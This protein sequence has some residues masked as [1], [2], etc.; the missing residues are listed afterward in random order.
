M[1]DRI[2][3]ILL[4]IR[5]DREAFAATA[6]GW[7]VEPL[8]PWK[9]PESTLG[10]AG[11][12]ETLLARP[13][14]VDHENPWDEAYARMSLR[15]EVLYAEPDIA[16]E[17]QPVAADAAGLALSGA[18]QG[19]SGVPERPQ[20]E[21]WH[22][23]DGYSQ[24]RR[25]RDK[26][27]SEGRDRSI[28][29]GILDTGYQPGHPLLPRKLRTDLGRDFTD[30]DRSSA[31]EPVGD[32]PFDNFGHGTSTMVL[33]AGQR[34][35]LNDTPGGAPNAEVLPVRI[36]E[37]VVLVYT[38]SM[39]R[40]IEYAADQ[41]CHV[42]SVSMGGLASQFWADAVNKAY[43]EG[44]CIV[45]ASGNNFGAPKAIVYPALFRR[46]IAACGVMSDGS[47]YILPFGQMSGNFGPNSKMDTALAAYTPDVVWARR[48]NTP[49]WSGS[50]AEAFDLKG[51]GTSS[52]T[53]QIAAAA[54]L[55]LQMHGTEFPSGGFASGWVRVENVRR[56][57]FQSARKQ[58][59]ACRCLGIG[60]L[61]ALRALEFQPSLAVTQTPRDNARLAFLKVLTGLGVEA[62]SPLTCMIGTEV[63]QLWQLDPALQAMVPDP[64]A[65]FAQR[66]VRGFLTAVAE[67]PRASQRLKAYVKDQLIGLPGSN[68][69]GRGTFSASKPVQPTIR[70]LRVFALDPSLSRTMTNSSIQHAVLGVRWENNLAPGPAGEYVEVID[71]D[72]VTGCFYPPVDLDD[73]YV[74]AQDGHAPSEGNPEFHQQTVYAVAMKVIQHFQTALGRP[75]FWRERRHEGKSEYVKR[76]RIYPHAFRGA[77]AWYSPERCALLFGY[78][79]SPREGGMVYTCLS[80]DI[81]AHETTHAVLDGLHPRLLEPTNPDVH[82]FH[83]A[84]ADLVALFGRFTL[85]ELVEKEIAATRGRLDAENLLGGLA[86]QFGQATQSRESLRSYTGLKPDPGAYINEKE[87][88]TRGALLVAAMYQAFLSI[89]E[90]RSSDLIRL[91][92]NGTG[93]LGAGEI[94]PDLVVRLTQEATKAARH[95]LNMSMR[96]LDYLPPVDI[97]FGE[98]L[99]AIITADVDLFADDKFG[100][101]T[102]LI[103]AFERWG[104]YPRE[105][106]TLSIDTLRWQSPSDDLVDGGDFQLLADQFA[107]YMGE[108]GQARVNPNNNY[109]ENSFHNAAKWRAHLQKWLASRIST[110]NG[111]AKLADALGLDPAIVFEGE[112]QGE[113]RFEVHALRRADRIGPDKVLRQII[114]V[115]TQWRK[116]TP[117][118][119][120]SPVKFRGGATIVFDIESRKVRYCIRKRIRSFARQE[121]F[122][123]FVRALSLKEF[124]MVSLATLQLGPRTFAA[125][126]PFR[127]MHSFPDNGEGS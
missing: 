78:F 7:D 54:A 14:T 25:A 8:F 76:L 62:P 47:P 85:T 20:R 44:V 56:A 41:G 111:G 88:H 30:G 108:E 116:F 59:E 97:S 117:E 113:P 16:S 13:A 12:P 68:G 73:R 11:G 42:I 58:E 36:S 77:N 125:L 45:A 60:T 123:E 121:R 94:H 28:R 98:F 79:Q 29:I 120:T 90:R 72:P 52:A 119:F 86:R 21:L 40:G 32:V 63:T 70:R 3:G 110:Q 81:V 126:E 74:M 100:Y 106:R 43:D 57:L 66:Q 38:S 61:R 84:F 24:L 91:A 22:L 31:I 39:A 115:L 95:I 6:S 33:L 109:R 122:A 51:G 18:C 5:G 82:A 1:P 46:V 75:V 114:L 23:D 69:P 50:G 89:Y 10:M 19:S 99:R 35:P 118:G 53:P 112:R 37:R 48:S 67:H 2:R 15:P 124:G 4:K 64:D 101:R 65:G 71:H 26:A 92:T 93:V 34:G 103:E 127:M 96:A 107:Q 55:W 17:I 102:A 80:S 9:Q 87:S 83:E 27:E 49:E 104:L 105:L